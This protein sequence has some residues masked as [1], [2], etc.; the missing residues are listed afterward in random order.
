MEEASTN[1]TSKVKGVEVDFIPFVSLDALDNTES[2][3]PTILNYAP[4]DIL[5]NDWVSPGSKDWIIFY[6]FE[7]IVDQGAILGYT[8]NGDVLYGGCG[9]LYVGTNIGGEITLTLQPYYTLFRFSGSPQDQLFT[10]WNDKYNNKVDG[11]NY[12]FAAVKRGN[13]LLHFGYHE[14][15]TDGE[16]LGSYDMTAVKADPTIG[17]SVTSQWDNMVL[18]GTIGLSHGAYGCTSDRCRFAEDDGIGNE[19]WVR[20]K[21]PLS[22]VCGNP[23]YP[24]WPSLI[25]DSPQPTVEKYWPQEILAY[26]WPSAPNPI[27]GESTSAGAVNY[28][29]KYWFL[30]Q[31]VFDYIAPDNSEIQTG[32]KTMLDNA[33]LGT[34]E[35]PDNW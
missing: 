27:P 23:R 26:Q 35:L 34:K 14:G 31:L 9:S 33:I 28:P 5:S 15:D 30:G 7:A 6:G 25:P 4:S 3:K 2:G 22:G 16:L 21:F 18:N 19:Y 20:D 32:L 12:A 13:T 8:T 10:P 17:A 24:S 11:D 29:Q 1:F